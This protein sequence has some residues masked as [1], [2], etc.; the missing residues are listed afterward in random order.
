MPSSSWVRLGEA[1]LRLDLS[2]MGDID[3]TPMFLEVI[4]DQSPV[5]VVRL[6]FAAKQASVRD[7]FR[8]NGFFDPPLFHERKEAVLIRPPIPLLLLVLVQDIP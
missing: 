4:R 1:S 3:I 7:H 5:T 6:V 8:W 2:K